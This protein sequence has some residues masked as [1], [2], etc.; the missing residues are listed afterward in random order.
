[1]KNIDKVAVIGAGVMGS[2][3]AAQVANA[4]VDVLLLDIVPDKAADRN[5]LAQGAIDRL[6]KTD[7]APLMHGRNARQITPGNLED[8]LGKLADCD[9]IIEVV[10]EN[11]EIKQALYRKLEQHRK[12]GSVV[13]SNTSTLD[14]RARVILALSSAV[15]FSLKC[16][17]ISFRNLL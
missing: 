6:K 10:L 11:L 8:D 16:L 2:G 5:V 7:P 3:I 9:W 1:M 13:S 17:R 4:G 12:P 14:T 15:A